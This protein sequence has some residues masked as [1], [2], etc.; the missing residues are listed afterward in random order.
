MRR[1][2]GNGRRPLIIFCSDARFAQVDWFAFLSGGTLHFIY[3][4]AKA[5]LILADFW[6]SPMLTSLRRTSASALPPLTIF[7]SLCALQ[8][9]QHCTPAGHGRQQSRRRFI[10]TQHRCAV[11]T[12]PACCATETVNLVVLRVAAAGFCNNRSTALVSPK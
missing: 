9:W 7:H 11:L 8:L 12:P 1:T 2:A 4:L 5:T 10:P 6:S 3:L